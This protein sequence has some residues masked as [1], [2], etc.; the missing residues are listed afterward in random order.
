VPVATAPTADLV[1]PNAG[2]GTS[3]SFI[4]KY[5]SANGNGY[6]RYV[7][8]LINGTLNGN[9]ACWVYYS[10]ATNGLF[11]LNDTQST[12][13]GPL[14]PGS[15]GTLQNSQ[16]TLNGAGSSVTGA[17]NTLAMTLALTFKP[18]FSG[19]QTAFGQAFDNASLTSGWQALGMWKT[20]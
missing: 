10:A 6:L 20:N 11:L 19:T 14:T 1:T 16:C 3:G 18:S 2:A 15:N 4:F 13:T 7:H 8:A 5:S 12:S 9:G 17:G